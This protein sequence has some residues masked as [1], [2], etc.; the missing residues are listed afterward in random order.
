M[1]GAIEAALKEAALPPLS[2]YDVLLE[3]SRDPNAGLRQYAIGERLLLNKHNLSRLIDRLEHEG[4]VRR[5]VCDSDGRGNVVKITHKG[6]Q[7]KETMW[8]VYAKKIQALIAEPLT[9]AQVRALAEIMGR[10][11]E[12]H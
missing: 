10:L 1:L 5:Q 3:L 7:L 6:L 9:P 8:P 11:L 4:L 2:W 12:P